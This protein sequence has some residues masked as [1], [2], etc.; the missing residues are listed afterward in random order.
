METAFGDLPALDDL[1]RI[2]LRLA[3]AAL[4]GGIVGFEREWMGKPAGIRTHMMVALGSAAF[5]L[6]ATELAASTADTLRVVQ[7]VA[8]GIGFIGAGTILKHAERQEVQG[9]T[10]AASIWVTG[11]TGIAVG[12][13]RFWL[14]AMCVGISLLILVAFSSLDRWVERRRGGEADGA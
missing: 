5:L 6:V 4:L 8:T 11:A 13:G 7:G 14:A 10:T 12:A 2:A 1:F 9:I 3:A